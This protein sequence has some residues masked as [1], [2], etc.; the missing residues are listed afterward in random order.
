MTILRLKLGEDSSYVPGR[1]VFEAV[2]NAIRHPEANLLQ[3]SSS[4]RSNFFGRSRPED[5][6]DKGTFT[7]H[8][9]DDGVGIGK[10]LLRAISKGIEVK[11]QVDDDLHRNFLVAISEDDKFGK[12]STKE[13]ALYN[14]RM[15]IN[16]ISDEYLA[17][18]ATLFPGVTS[19]PFDSTHKVSEEVLEQD[20]RYGGRGMGLHVL[21]NAVTEVLGGSVAIRSG[22]YFLNVRTLN[23]PEKREYD[24]NHR[25]RIH[26][27]NDLLPEFLGNLITIRL[28]VGK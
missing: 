14:S 13:Y 25:V 27:R 8:F 12:P 20:E 10:T 23:A 6:P 19:S 2:L 16:S 28:P 17:L 5:T 15:E 1:I 24:A 22:K 26:C 3:T 11:N 7:I 21:V 9:W 4:Y 18:L